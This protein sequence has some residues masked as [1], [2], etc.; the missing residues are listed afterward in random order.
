[1]TWNSGNENFELVRDG[2]APPARGDTKLVI[3]SECFNSIC[4]A[5]MSNI[6]TAVMEI[7]GV[8]MLLLD[9]SWP[10]NEWNDKRQQIC[11]MLNSHEK[12]CQNQIAL[13]LELGLWKANMKKADKKA[14]SKIRAEYRPN[15]GIE[16]I[17]ENVL[18]FLH[19]L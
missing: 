19:F 16:M 1:M 4:P 12:H 17:Q 6:E 11:A 7:I 5:D 2:F 3:T 13:L 8:E 15:H 14:N 18:S 10:S 9:T